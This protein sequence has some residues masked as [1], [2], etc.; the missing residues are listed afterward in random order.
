MKGE[1]HCETAQIGALRAAIVA[2]HVDTTTLLLRLGAPVNKGEN[3]KPI[4]VASQLG[5]KEI[6]SLLLQY[7]A[8]LTSRTYSGNRAL[9]LA[10]E[11]GHLSLVKYLVEEHTDFVNDLNFENET[12]LHF[13]A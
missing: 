6:V 1:V 3:E 13:A 10:S 4:H 5:R 12:P 9:H 2:G 11:N 8:I 7:G